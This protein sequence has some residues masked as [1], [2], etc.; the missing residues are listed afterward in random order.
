MW[1][2]ALRSNP[3][4]C[5]QVVF[6]LKKNSHAA[7]SLPGQLQLQQWTICLQDYWTPAVGLQVEFTVKGIATP[8]AVSLSS[9]SL[10][11]GS[12]EAGASSSRVLYLH[13][14]CEVPAFFELAMD[15]AGVFGADRVRGSIAAGSTAHV[16]LRFQPTVS[17]NYWKRITVL[18]KVGPACGSHVRGIS[19]V[20]LDT[21]CWLPHQLQVVMCG[22][23]GQAWLQ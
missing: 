10:S 6:K 20:C 16:T 17:A 7:W 9:S 18:I 22:Q 15:A 19:S 21:A 14:T 12:L 8:P 2:K 4:V 3:A 1:W 11:F 5:L 23:G 13:N